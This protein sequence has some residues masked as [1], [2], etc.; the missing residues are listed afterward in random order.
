MKQWWRHF[1]KLHIALLSAGALLAPTAAHA[2]E[3]TYSEVGS[4]EGE[5]LERQAFG[6]TGGELGCNG[7]TARGILNTTDFTERRLTVAYSVCVAF[8]IAAVHV[9]PAHFRFWA[10]G[11]AEIEKAITIDVTVPLLPDCQV[12]IAPQT[13][14][15][16]GYYNNDNNLVIT[17]HLTGI[18]YTSTGGLC[19]SSGSNGTFTGA[20]EVNRAGGGW[21]AFDP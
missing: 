17:P 21:I 9:S 14:G 3:F 16:V 6:F 20:I 12:A 10:S 1:S 15:E 13:V 7:A 4:I 5:A 11:E 2:A 18:S 19:G 8:G